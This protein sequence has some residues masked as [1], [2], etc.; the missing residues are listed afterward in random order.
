VFGLTKKRRTM[1]HRSK[2]QRVLNLTV[3]AVVNLSHSPTIHPNLIKFL[4]GPSG[5]LGLFLLTIASFSP[6]MV[7]SQGPVE[8]GLLWGRSGAQWAGNQAATATGSP[9][10]GSLRLDWFWI[11]WEYWLECRI[12]RMT[13]WGYGLLW[14]NLINE[15]GDINGIF[16]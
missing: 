6:P 10:K 16:T 14:C 4:R 3:T 1:T 11:Q 7:T 2:T 5:I 15:N 9:M 13:R 8:L 12:D